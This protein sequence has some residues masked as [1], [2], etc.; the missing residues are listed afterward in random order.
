[1]AS[2]NS[3]VATST[4]VEECYSFNCCLQWLG[5]REMLLYSVIYFFSLFAVYVEE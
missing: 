5:L 2:F 4:P 3:N 1:M